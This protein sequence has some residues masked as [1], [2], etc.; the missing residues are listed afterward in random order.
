[1]RIES[2][3]DLLIWQRSM[4]LAEAV[5][6]AT[7][8]FPKAE[9]Y[10]LTA[11]MRRAAVSIPSNIA[12]GFYRSTR[13]DYAHFLSIA[14]GSLMELETQLLLAMRFRYTSAADGDALV[15]EIGELE[16]MVSSLRSKV[17][18]AT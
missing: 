4:D 15:A 17:S 9:V 10:G 5:Y 18:S 14:K 7:T 13:K 1:M 3:R 2:H 12:E 8:S 16:R 11:Q 6:R